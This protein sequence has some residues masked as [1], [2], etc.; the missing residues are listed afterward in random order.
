MISQGAG[1]PS[2]PDADSPQATPA[3]KVKHVTP[4]Y[5]PVVH[6]IPELDDAALEAV[7]QWE[8]TPRRV[9]GEP[10]PVRMTVTIQFSL[11]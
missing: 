7:K 4:V 3:T 9:D 10:M 8:Y 6:S 11:Q 2:S 1:R 5:P